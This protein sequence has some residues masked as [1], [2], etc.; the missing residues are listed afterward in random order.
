MDQQ[1][2]KLICQ[3][4]FRTNQYHVHDSCKTIALEEA[5]KSNLPMKGILSTKPKTKPSAESITIKK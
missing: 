1:W 2:A 5:S 3:Q 4:H